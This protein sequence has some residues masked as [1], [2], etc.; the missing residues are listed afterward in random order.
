MW[1]QIR[2]NR[3]RSAML[4]V[5]MAL[6]L[7]V[8]G[9]VLGLL[10][11]G[12][13]IF[14][15]VLAA[16]LWI[17]MTLVAYYGANDIFLSISKAKKINK[18][19]HPRLFNVVEEMKIA[20][21]LPK[22][23]DIYIIDTPAMNAFATGRDPEHAAIAVT[24]GL[25]QKL[26][27]DELQGV[28][29]HEM[30][31]IKNRDILLMMIAGVM[32]GTIV[33]LADMAMWYLFF[34]A[35]TGGGRSSRRDNGGGGQGQIIILLAAIVL[36]ILAPILAQLMYF[37]I[38]R[39]REYLADASGA[40]YTRYPDGLASALEKL[41]SSTAELQSANR[42]TAPMYIVNP[43]KK[44]GMKVS[45]L[46]STHPPISERIR[47]LRSMGGGISLADYDKAFHQVHQKG[48][49]S[50]IPA[51]ALAGGGLG[52]AAPA[53]ES[54]M[55]EREPEEI[56]RARET[57]DIL[58]KLNNYTSITCDCGTKLKIPPKFKSSTVRC[59]HCGTSN[60]IPKLK[61]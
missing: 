54:K 27:R 39:K 3:N 22:I 25:L 7:S 44:K 12:S 6:L 40:L 47:I 34:G 35:I 18:Q 46:S 41:S 2:A 33:M 37:A 10:F 19:D 32:M 28:I 13:G 53:V 30:A 55:V 20:S 45:D 42:T 36:I 1:E 23:P 11:A 48:T 49:G 8:V 24:S 59:P 29:A 58:W 57:S 38:S 21:G 5:S 60:P 15:L 56:D 50:V 61:G 4:V 51:S 31:H 9:Y 43:L 17:I 52:L 14:G 26:N 16:I